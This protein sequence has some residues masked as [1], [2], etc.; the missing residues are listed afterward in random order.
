MNNSSQS[1]AA[2]ANPE[3]STEPRGSMALLFSGG[4]DTTLEVIERGKTYKDIYLLTFDNG[5]C[6]NLGSATRRLD[7]LRR[8][9]RSDGIHHILID[10]RDLMHKLLKETA[11]LRNEFHSPLIFDLA[12]KMSAISH[13][14]VFAR[15]HGVTDISDGAAVEQTQVFIQHPDF[16]K[17]IAPLVTDYGL[18][19]VKPTGF[20]MGRKEKLELLAKY[21]LSDGIPALEKVHITSQLAYQP[22]CMRGFVTFFFTSPLRH[23]P[24]VKSMSL[25]LDQACQLWD[26]IVPTAREFI[27]Q[28]LQSAS[29]R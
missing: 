8:I 13:L 27:D 6:I 23:L 20:N 14:I 29:G 9:T 22:F 4:L 2:Q 18:R 21:G 19:F 25:P 11:L 3:S 1:D 24:M 28:A 10:T 12:C 7:D 26:R 5:C 17:H 15:T 16:S